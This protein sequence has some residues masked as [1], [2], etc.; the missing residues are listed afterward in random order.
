MVEVRRQQTLRFD[1]EASATA[2]LLK[3]ASKRLEKI[4][5]WP[6]TPG[7]ITVLIVNDGTR[8]AKRVRL[9]WDAVRAMGTENETVNGRDDAVVA[10]EPGSA[11]MILASKTPFKTSL[12]VEL[13]SR[14]IP[15]E[16]LAIFYLAHESHH[17]SEPERQNSLGILNR[18]AASRA[19][20]GVQADFSDSWLAAARALALFES[21]APTAEL[22]QAVDA[23]D[24]GAADA[25][26]L[27]MVREAGLPW[28][29]LCAGV[30]RCRAE[31]ADPGYRVAWLLDKLLE[32]GL[33]KSR[34]DLYSACWKE[35]FGLALDRGLPATHADARRALEAALASPAV[36]LVERA[37]SPLP[38]S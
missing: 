19:L 16:V 31:S 33:P 38:G 2:E 37:R 17:V 21:A 18:E 8:P 26:G 10:R 14:K 30:S 3:V 25:L 28:E 29:D 4:G 13:T 9:I 1:G 27:W 34:E 23:L 6:A 24:E 5:A 20:R 32:Q 7:M 35:A 36:A 12:G 11:S 22:D 15:Q